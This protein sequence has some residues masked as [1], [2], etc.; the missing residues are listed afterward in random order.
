VC[1]KGKYQLCELSVDYSVQKISLK[2]P[3]PTITA[4]DMVTNTGMDKEINKNMDRD[5]DTDMEIDMNTGI[6]RDNFK[7]M[8]YEKVRLLKV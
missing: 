5:K 6:D 2:S 4:T 7:Q 8:L 3:I 1:G